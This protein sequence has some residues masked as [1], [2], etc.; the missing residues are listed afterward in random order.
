VGVP[1]ELLEGAA[2][3]EVVEAHTALEAA[4]RQPERLLVQ[5]AL[6]QLQRK[7]DI[8]N[9]KGPLLFRIWGRSK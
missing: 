2:G 6:Q 3:I 8:R 5:A 4:Q 7:K 9:K 1:T